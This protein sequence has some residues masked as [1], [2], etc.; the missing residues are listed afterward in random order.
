MNK[1]TGRIGGGNPGTLPRGRR[2]TALAMAAFAVGGDFSDAAKRDRPAFEQSFAM[3]DFLEDR[4]IRMGQ[5][6]QR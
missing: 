1:H 5:E 6:I 3:D 2:I 4:G